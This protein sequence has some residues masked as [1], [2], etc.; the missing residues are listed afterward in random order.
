MIVE[1]LNFQSIIM[2]SPSW[3]VKVVEKVTDVPTE[4]FRESFG[5]TPAPL[6]RPEKHNENEHKRENVQTLRLPIIKTI[7]SIKTILLVWI[8]PRINL[9]MQMN[10]QILPVKATEMIQNKAIAVCFLPK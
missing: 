6:I 1:S 4:A 9:R 8:I 7:K 2:N 10:S 3:A 5:S